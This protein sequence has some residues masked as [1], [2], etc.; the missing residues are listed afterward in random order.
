MAKTSEK[1]R[2][3]ARGKGVAKQRTALTR[4][5][6]ATAALEIIEGEGLAALSTRR[7]GDALGCEA[8]SIYHYFPS[9]Q[10]IVDACVDHVVGTFE[11]PPAGTDPLDR[12]RR[13]CAAYRAL[14]RKHPRFFPYIAVYRHNTPTGVRFIEG[15]LGAV[16]AVVRDRER[17]ARYFRVLG[18]YLVGAALDETSG[19][20]AGPSAAEPVTDAYVAEHCPRLATAAP[21]FKQAH[22]NATFDLGLDALLARMANEPRLLRHRRSA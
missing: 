22:W 14:A 3:G 20:A 11:L 17:A 4:E 7:L 5:R 8:M 21:Y 6:I 1:P 19:Y 2:S 13:T 9:K 16:E 15:I 18:Y 10:H 12:L